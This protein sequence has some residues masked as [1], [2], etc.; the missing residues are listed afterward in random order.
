[1]ARKAAERIEQVFALRR[2]A[3]RLL[4]ERRSLDSLLPDERRNGLN[5][6]RLQAELGHFC[7]WIEIPVVANPVWNPIG[8]E[9]HPDFFEVRGD[10][11]HFLQEAVA[12]VVE[13]LDA[14]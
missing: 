13:L 14:G 5:L 1:M 3:R 8:I 12:Q 2:I 9:L 10:A 11:L 7:R 6:F 4:I